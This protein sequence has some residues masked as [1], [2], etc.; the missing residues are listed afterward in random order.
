MGN[1]EA[2][3]EFDA[4]RPLQPPLQV[5]P[6]SKAFQ[7][8]IAANL[9][10]MFAAIGPARGFPQPSVWLTAIEA[11]MPWIAVAAALCFPKR[12]VIFADKGGARIPL[13]G[14]WFFSVLALMGG[15][16]YASLVRKLPALELGLVTGSV[17]FAG[18]VAAHVRARGSLV[19]LVV[20][21][22]LS[23]G[24]GYGT[25]SQANYVLDRSPATAYK[26]VVS[27]KYAG[28]HGSQFLYLD[29]WGANP[30]PKSV[31]APYK[32]SVPR[33]TYD[34]VHEGGPVCVNQKEGGLGMAWF[35]AQA[36]L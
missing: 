10:L 9:V 19:N 24:C 13:F 5:Q 16:D 18:A 35:T 23:L 31:T 22:P 25:A 14:V 12:C 36:C 21:L 15:F 7:F 32:V 28:H 27:E 33:E 26:T 3:G 2:G 4:R 34:L 8:A 29:P 1:Q 20:V 11:G 30:A 17:L 6:P